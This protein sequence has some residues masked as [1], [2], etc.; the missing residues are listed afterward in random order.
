MYIFVFVPY[1]FQLWLLMLHAGY[2]FIA[3][4]KWSSHNGAGDAFPAV[5]GVCSIP[6]N[7]DHILYYGGWDPFSKL[8]LV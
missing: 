8:S 5:T 2:T 4:W 3:Q 6:L 7:D 1:C